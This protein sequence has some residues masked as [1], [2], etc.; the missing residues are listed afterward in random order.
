MGMLW[1]PFA[2]VLWLAASALALLLGSLAP[3]SSAKT[4]RRGELKRH[5]EEYFIPQ[6]Q[7]AGFEGP[8]V[9]SGNNLIFKF[10]RHQ[11]DLHHF[12]SIQFEKRGGPSCRIHFA[13]E[14]EAGIQERLE[15]MKK[16]GRDAALDM[17]EPMGGKLGGAL[18]P[19]RIPFIRGAFW[20][21][22]GNPYYRLS[23]AVH[24]KRPS[25]MLA[26]CMA[27]LFTDEI[28]PWWKHRALG[29]HLDILE[30][31]LVSGDRRSP[32]ARVMRKLIWAYQGYCVFMSGLVG[33]LAVIVPA[34]LLI[35]GVLR[36]FSK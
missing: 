6:L 18:S 16:A 10:H 21:R 30:H 7:S 33:L 25:E 29:P 27:R 19:G 20:F 4:S 23:A 11:G 2:V 26:R 36:L 34:S 28:E 35:R 17:L 13:E 8:A 14:T 12:L 15:M 5:L 3:R 9:L 32:R 22:T 1:L 31:W 24:R